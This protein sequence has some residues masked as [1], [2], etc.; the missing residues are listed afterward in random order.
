MIKFI[1]Y[2][3]IK[4][5]KKVHFFICS[6]SHQRKSQFHSRLYFEN[7]LALSSILPVAVTLETF[8]Q[9][10]PK[11]KENGNV[12]KQTNTFLLSQGGWESWRNLFSLPLSRWGEF[13]H[14]PQRTCSHFLTA[15]VSSR[16]LFENFSLDFVLIQSTSKAQSEKS[17]RKIIRPIFHSLCYHTST[18]RVKVFPKQR[19]ENID[20]SANVASFRV[21]FIS[22]LILRSVTSSTTR[23]IFFRHK[24]TNFN[25]IIAVN[26]WNS[27]IYIFNFSFSR[28]CPIDYFHH[29]RLLFTHFPTSVKTQS[30]IKF[31]LL[32]REFEGARGMWVGRWRC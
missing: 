24:A 22:G 1:L 7:L 30:R 4:Y 11:E 13:F 25:K 20:F 28:G 27:L 18:L 16:G 10:I 26:A 3:S 17:N 9:S 14:N 5:W 19:K 6:F 32:T 21:M 29:R 23:T 31:S 12:R 2:F 15:W 8:L